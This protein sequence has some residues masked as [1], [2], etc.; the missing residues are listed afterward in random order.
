M[1]VL[2]LPDL[3]FDAMNEAD[4]RAEVVEPIL[5]S[6]G[7]GPGTENR[8]LR[9]REIKLRYERLFLGR[10]KPDKDPV[11]RG[12][13][14]YVCV[15]GDFGRWVIEA[16]PPDKGIG[17]DDVE[18]AHSYAAHPEI[19]A[20]L[21][22]LT[23]GRSFEIRETLR[24]PEANPLIRVGYEELKQNPHPLQNL[25]GPDG[26]RARYPTRALDLGEPL[27]PGLGSA[28]KIV[29]GSS[30]W[31]KITGFVDGL[32]H[33]LSYADTRELD[34]LI[35]LR[36]SVEGDAIYRNQ[37]GKIVADVRSTPL[38]PAEE[39]LSQVLGTAVLRY[40]CEDATISQ[41]PERPSTFE[42]SVLA[43]V[44]EGA[45]T[46]SLA[47]WKTEVVPATSEVVYYAQALGHLDGDRLI[48]KLNARVLLQQRLL[49][50]SVDLHL[51][52]EGQIE[53]RLK[54]A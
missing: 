37:A 54:V 49:D 2:D 40:L 31:E 10:K 38:H 27:T 8:L 28:M 15:V 50:V 6:L 35:D 34:R 24:G 39:E 9:E 16:K 14:D 25:L 33:G 44:P 26:F 46:L 41:D 20:P 11:L 30:R 51:I 45:E 36:L 29:G 3:D 4:V 23:N 47:K 48:G 5:R 13:P 18:Q 52:V 17:L 7:Y 19:Q 1:P 43:T 53:L 32:P 12:R 42:T 22:V 21:F